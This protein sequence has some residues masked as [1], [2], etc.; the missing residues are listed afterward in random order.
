LGLLLGWRL[1]IGS[2]VN[3]VILATLDGIKKNFGGFLDALEKLIVLS[4]TNSSLFVGVMLQDL[5]PVS[6]L[7]LVLSCTISVSGQTEDGI[8]VLALK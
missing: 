5:L 7:D 6:A 1:N 3:G 4:S 8:V 2:F